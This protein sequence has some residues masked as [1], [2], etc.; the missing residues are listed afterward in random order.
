MQQS[1]Q[2][3]PL[4]RCRWAAVSGRSPPGLEPG[5]LLLLLLS[6]PLI[7]ITAAAATERLDVRVKPGWRVVGLLFWLS[8]RPA[9]QNMSLTRRQRF[10]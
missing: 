2:S 9:R 10:C 5:P 6:V 7:P 3:P 8:V 4:A 1:K